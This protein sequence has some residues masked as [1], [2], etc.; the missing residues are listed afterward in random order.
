MAFSLCT[1]LTLCS[2]S[3]FLS[4]HSYVG[5]GAS[6]MTSSELDHLQTPHFPIRSPSQIQGQ[7]FSIFLGDTIQC[8]SPSQASWGRLP[9]ERARTPSSV[10]GSSSGR[11]PTKTSFQ[12]WS[13]RSTE[14]LRKCP[15]IMEQVPRRNHDLSQQFLSYLRIYF[16]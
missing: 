4:R 12:T 10:S 2:S 3:P 7:D 16:S 6:L 8:V 13:P 5:L 1:C 9:I 11:A 15:A 14:R